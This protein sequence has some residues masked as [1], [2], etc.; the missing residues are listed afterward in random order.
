MVYLFGVVHDIEEAEAIPKL[1][2]YLKK[3]RVLYVEHVSLFPKL[4]HE[5]KKRGVKVSSLDEPL[6]R[7]LLHKAPYGDI[8][9]FIDY[10]FREQR[11]VQKLSGAKEKDLVVAFP[12]HV[13][14]LARKMPEAGKV[15]FM[16]PTPHFYKIRM[17]RRLPRSHA[18]VVAKYVEKLLRLPVAEQRKQALNGPKRFIDI[19]KHL[20]K[21]G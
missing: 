9:T 10:D 7:K 15:V 14:E 18:R 21:R 12:H 5:A 11:W 20:G 1:I 8:H 4:V 6:D 13:R 17:V 16:Q 2:P 3:G 19:K